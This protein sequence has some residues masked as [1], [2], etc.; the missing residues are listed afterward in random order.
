MYLLESWGGG[1]DEVA[2][3]KMSNVKKYICESC[4]KSE[5]QFLEF[6]TIVAVVLSYIVAGNLTTVNLRFTYTFEK[7]YVDAT[8]CKVTSPVIRRPICLDKNLD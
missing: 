7:E 3:I 6:Y 5:M 4:V 8:P 2:I 1:L